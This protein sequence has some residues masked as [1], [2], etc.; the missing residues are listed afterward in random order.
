MCQCLFRDDEQ[1]SNWLRVFEGWSENIPSN[2]EETSC[3]L[4]F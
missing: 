2:M 4:K 3:R 1:M